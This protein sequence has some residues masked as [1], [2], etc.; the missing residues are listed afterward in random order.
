MA[1]PDVFIHP[2][3]VVHD[4]AHIGAGTKI[5]HFCHVMAGAVIGSKCV[6]GQN[7]FVANKVV[8]GNNCKVQNNVS[9]YEGIVCEDDVFLGPSAV[10]TNV[11]NP[12]AFIERKT[13]FRQTRIGRGATVGANATIICGHNLGAY[14][15]VGAGAV[16]SKDV[17]PHALVLGV[18][19]AVAGWVSKAGQRLTFDAAGHATCP[20]TGERYV[21]KDGGVTPA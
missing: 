5:W 15:L 18:P 14:C 9:L 21:L 4:D 17:P 12:R 3:A 7:V 11:I 10:F 20:E 6:L 13:E 16:V 1:H 8:L 19:A 2:T